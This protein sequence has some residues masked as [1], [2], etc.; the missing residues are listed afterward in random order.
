MPTFRD[1]SG[2]WKN[3]KPEELA[4]PAAFAKDPELVWKW[5][6]WRRKLLIECAPNCAHEILARW[7]LRLNSFTLI[8]QNVD[9]LHEQAGT[10][11]VLRFH[12]S[13]W[14][15]Q[16]WQ[17]C[18]KAP[19]RWVNKE[20]P[21]KNF[22]PRCP[23]CNGLARP[24][25]V[26]FGEIIDRSVLQQSL[27]STSC[28]VFLV[29][30]TSAIVQPAAS[31]VAEAARRGAYTVEINLESTPASELVDLSLYGAAE[32]LLR[33]IDKLLAKFKNL[34]DIKPARSDL[35]I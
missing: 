19:S 11:E 7:S 1:K 31:L 16:C 18:Q 24:G 6:A 35:S 23:H 5:Y 22:P 21:F 30:G 26:W 28:D 20:V 3:R 8:T 10:K 13:I 25:V 2:L 15:L 33:E 4:T 32:S 27:A 17:A 12:G 34:K 29:V 9:G 14:D